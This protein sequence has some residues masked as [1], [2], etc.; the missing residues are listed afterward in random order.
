MTMDSQPVLSCIF[1]RRSIRSYVDN[2]P[3]EREK[4]EI[5]LQAAMAAPSA[6]NL[7]PWEFIIIDDPSE[8]KAFKKLVRGGQFNAPMAMIV[9]AR[10]SYVPWEG[11][12]WQIDCA[13]AIENMMLAAVEMGLGSL[14]IGD[15]NQQGVRELLNI[16]EGVEPMSVVYF[17]YPAEHK[18]P[19]TR[20]KEEAVYWGKYDPARE[21]TPRT[22]RGMIQEGIDDA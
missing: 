12:G 2:K 6:C 21:H 5:L 13:A 3:V 11:N 22:I 15:Y 16:P 18:R 1:A 20:Y 17:G 8:M 9:C 19:V 14:W 4:I 7:Q 10:T